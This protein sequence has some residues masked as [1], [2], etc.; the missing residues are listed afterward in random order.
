MR[1]TV[2]VECSKE[3]KTVTRISVIR[4]RGH[5][6]VAQLRVVQFAGIINW[7]CITKAHGN[8]L[9]AWTDKP[10]TVR[11]MVFGGWGWLGM[12]LSLCFRHENDNLDHG[13]CRVVYMP[14]FCEYSFL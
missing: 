7:P 4:S 10:V 13:V 6:M 12:T 14:M 1:S 5:T 11:I 8:R 9:A 2:Q 3:L